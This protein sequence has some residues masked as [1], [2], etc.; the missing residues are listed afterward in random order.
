MEKIAQEWLGVADEWIDSLSKSLPVY[1]SF[2]TPNP[3]K[4][5]NPAISCLLLETQFGEGE[6]ATPSLCW[7]K[8]PSQNHRLCP[9]EEEGV[10]E[11]WLQSSTVLFFPF[12]I[13]EAGLEMCLYYAEKP[14]PSLQK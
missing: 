4:Q 2:R 7:L 14:V 12:P 1:N 9:L 10:T 11:P 8:D 3:A 13:P 6:V 5:P